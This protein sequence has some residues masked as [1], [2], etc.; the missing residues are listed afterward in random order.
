M[1]NGRPIMEEDLHAF[2]DQIL[3]PARQAEVQVQRCCMDWAGGAL[4]WSAV[5][6]L[7]LL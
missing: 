4:G 7:L 1:T 5:G 2:A 6:S 3:D